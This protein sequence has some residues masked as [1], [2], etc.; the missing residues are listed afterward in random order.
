MLDLCV[1]SGEWVARVMLEVIW[2]V[3]LSC[4]THHNT[5]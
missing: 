1:L 2:A 5:E 4:Y 3:V